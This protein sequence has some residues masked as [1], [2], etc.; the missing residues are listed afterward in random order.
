MFRLAAVGGKAVCKS[1]GSAMQSVRAASALV[2]QI[3]DSVA[4]L[5]MREA[6]RYT[7]KNMKWTAGEFLDFVDAHANA[8][9]EHGF[10]AGD[11]IAL[12]LPD[13]AEKHV[14]L[15][16][17]A[18]MG[19]KVVD[20]DTSISSVGDL[21]AALTAANACTLFFEPVTASSDN[22][23]LLRKA[24][25]EFFHYDDTYG[26]PFHSKYF[27]SL[28]WFVHT[29]FDIE[30]GCLNYKSLFLKNPSASAVIGAQAATT[31][32]QPLYAKLA[33]GAGAA[34]QWAKQGDVLQHPEWAF[35]SK[36]IKKEYFETA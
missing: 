29:G 2:S 1:S 13:A 14:T 25:P 24:I 22:L 35:A 30:I 8:L 17:A 33:A 6:V 9:L 10:K 26:Q 21:R 15:L 32:D 20:L 12:W 16:A 36:L 4:A 28:K 27:P 3:N 18:K 34:P 23:L 5:P 7:N 31:D 19:L 11:T